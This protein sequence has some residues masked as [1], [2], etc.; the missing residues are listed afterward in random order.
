MLSGPNTVVISAAGSRKTQRIVDEALDATGPVLITTYTNENRAQIVRRIERA[1]GL[2]PDHITIMG[3][4]SFLI[5]QC[6]KPYQRAI[7]G[8]PLQIGGLNFVAPTTDRRIPRTNAR[9]YYFDRNYDVYR[10]QVAEFVHFLNDATDGAVMQRLGRIYSHVFVDEVQDLAGWDLE[11]LDLLFESP[12]STLAVGDP[13]QSTFTTNRSPKNKKYRGAG[14]V[15]WFEER[16][17]RCRI[18]T[19]KENY[20]CTQAICDFADALFPDLPPTLSTDVRDSDHSGIFTVLRADVP[21]YVDEHRP[22]VLQDR[23]NTDTLGL[24]AMNIGVAKGSTFDRVLIFPTGP[25][26]KYLQDGDSSKLKAPERFYV[27]VTRAR[28]SVAFVVD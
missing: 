10:G 8:A 27:A 25:M 17:E 20:R 7:T 3:W 9:H 11:V 16:P 1:A 26:K 6:A 14:I 4:F 5:G 23:K 13:R 21:A 24:P 12:I 2:V 19:K 22:Q 18:E 15:D 28:Y